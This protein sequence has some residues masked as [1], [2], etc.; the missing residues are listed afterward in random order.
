MLSFSGGTKS[1]F[2]F[3]MELLAPSQKR[4]EPKRV[5][6]VT[7]VTLVCQ[8][9]VQDW[10]DMRVTKGLRLPGYSL[11]AFL[12]INIQDGFLD[13]IFICVPALLF[14]TLR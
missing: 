13:F 3:M 4:N 12:C 14:G 5:L 10:I 11:L 7:K 2:I 8:I 1:D 9:D 6:G